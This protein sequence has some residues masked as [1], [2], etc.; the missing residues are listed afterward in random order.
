MPVVHN[1]MRGSQ[2]LHVGEGGAI[3]V[4]CGHVR[5]DDPRSSDDLFID[6]DRQTDTYMHT[7]M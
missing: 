4:A 7:V 5:V 3:M 1:S 2:W 6:T